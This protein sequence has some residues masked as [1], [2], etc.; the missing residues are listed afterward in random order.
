[1]AVDV[2]QG[3]RRPRQVPR[4]EDMVL[5]SEPSAGAASGHSG[6]LR[7]PCQAV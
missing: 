4:P 5:R 7:D 1:M 6:F 3:V 2:S